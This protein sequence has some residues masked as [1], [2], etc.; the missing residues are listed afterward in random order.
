[1]AALHEIAKKSSGPQ[2]LGL[3]HNMRSIGALYPALLVPY[4]SW[5][6]SLLND[7]SVKESAQGI[8]DLIEGRT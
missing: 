8:L 7:A 5:V 1:M 2:F 3:L 6:E 4:K